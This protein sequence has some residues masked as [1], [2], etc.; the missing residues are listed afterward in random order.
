VLLFALFAVLLLPYALFNVGGSTPT[1]GLGD[2]VQAPG[3]GWAAHPALKFTRIRP[4]TVTGTGFRPGERVSVELEKRRQAVTAGRAGG[5]TVRF[6][7]TA[8]CAGG[9]VV[10]VG[11]RGSRAV[12]NFSQ[13]LCIEP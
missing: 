9:T 7:R 5:F 12:A 2:V 8:T 13:L 10:A 11:S 4:I 6:G 3:G 1:T